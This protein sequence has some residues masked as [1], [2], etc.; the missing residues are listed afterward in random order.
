MISILINKMGFP[1]NGQKVYA[2]AAMQLVDESEAKHSKRT[3]RGPT[4]M[5]FPHTFFQALNKP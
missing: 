5:A 3:L 4:I 2:T 1:T